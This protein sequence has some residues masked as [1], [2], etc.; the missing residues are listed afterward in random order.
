MPDGVSLFFI[1]NDAHPPDMVKEFRVVNL[2]QQGKV[3]LVILIWYRMAPP[4]HTHPH[5][6]SRYQKIERRDNLVA[7]VLQG[8]DLFPQITHRN[9][10]QF[11]R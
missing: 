8:A 5:S 6:E 11:R 3:Y 4:R 1:K 2:M 10:G 7:L 9:T